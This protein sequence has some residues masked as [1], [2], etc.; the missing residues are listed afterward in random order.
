MILDC[1][2]HVWAGVDQLG[3]ELAQRIRT[4]QAEHWGQYDATPAA[5]ERM[6]DCVDGAIILGFRSERLGASIPNELIADYAARDPRRRIG[7]AGID[8]LAADASDQ[9]EKAIDLGLSGVAV[10]PASQGF[11]PSHSAAMHVYERCMELSMPLFVI[12]TDPIAP[13]AELEFARPTLWDEVAREFPKLPIVISQLGSPWIDETLTLLAKHEYM[14]SD[15]SGVASRPWQ[16]YTALLNANAYRVL[17]K[18]LFGSGFPFETPAKVIEA[19]YSLNAFS[20]GSQL[21]TVPRSQLRAIVERDV[22]SC[23]GMEA[24]IAP[25]LT[26]DGPRRAYGM[27]SEREPELSEVVPGDAAEQAGPPGS[28]TPPAVAEAEVEA[29]RRPGTNGATDDEA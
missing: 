15:I 26:Q 8:P 17:P 13:S 7:V 9:M 24:T 18:L 10:S 2:T 1:H 3:P 21:P 20:H 14:W 23:L 4:Q 6:M 5:H 11:H 22:I 12:G 29:E 28:P 19:I 27:A 25:R 16:L